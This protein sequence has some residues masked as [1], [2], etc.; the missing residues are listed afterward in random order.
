MSNPTFRAL[1]A[2]LVALD[3][4]CVVECTE[5]WAD[6]MCRVNAALAQPEPEPE[7]PTDEEIDDWRNYCAY[8]TRRGAADHYWAFDLQ[9]DDVAGV[10]RAALARWGTP[11]IQPVPVSERPWEQKSHWRDLDGECWW[12]P[13]DGPCYW[14]MVNPA[15]V[16][17]GWLL[18]AD[19]IPHPDFDPA[20]ARPT[21]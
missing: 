2:E 6:V 20:Y 19:A 18:P 4:H 16:Y 17:G 12:C 7:P 15:M 14:S 3:N 5:E 13:P 9:S 8:L 21:P 10:V 11:T 1:C